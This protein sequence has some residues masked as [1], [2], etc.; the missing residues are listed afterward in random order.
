MALHIIE[1]ATRDALMDAASERLANALKQAIN[2]RGSACAALSGGSTPGPA[3][4]ALAATQLD[5][6]RI[7]FALVDE[8]F[9]P[10]EH[11][12]SNEGLVRRELQAALGAGAHLVP[13]YAPASSVEN[14]ADKADTLYSRLRIDIALMGMGADGHTA[15]WFPGAARLG[16]AL[17]LNTARVVMALRAVQA[18]GAPERLTLTRSAFARIGRAV[19][20]ITGADKRARLEAAV[21]DGSAPVASLFD[22]ALPPPEV[23]WAE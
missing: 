3:Y 1:F 21:A 23:L 20:L 13:M 18:D 15:S 5:W 9:V 12:A 6:P 17:D 8:R 4:R 14:A 11:S 16:E 7:T 22:P 10:P 19:L 2:K